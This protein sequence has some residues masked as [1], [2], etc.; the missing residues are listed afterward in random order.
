METT[1]RGRFCLVMRGLPGQGAKKRPLGRGDG[2]IFIPHTAQYHLLFGAE[3]ISLLLGPSHRIDTVNPRPIPRPFVHVVGLVTLTV[4]LGVKSAVW[5]H[6]GALQPLAGLFSSAAPPRGRQSGVSGAKD[7]PAKVG[8]R[9]WG[10]QPVVR[11]MPK[12]SREVA[13]EG[14][15]LPGEEPMSWGLE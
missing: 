14:F 8:K 12:I 3:R 15:P 11:F 6:A 13:P 9:L 7:F 10:A 5:G 1:F 4:F 2:A